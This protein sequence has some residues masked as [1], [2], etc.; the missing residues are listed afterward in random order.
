MEKR[1]TNTNVTKNKNMNKITMNNKIIACNKT[2]MSKNMMKKGGGWKRVEK[3]LQQNKV[4]DHM[5]DYV[6]I[7][8]YTCMWHM[9]LHDY[10]V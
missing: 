8:V 1:I 10:V 6:N 9:W 3:S 7:H 2:M 4:Q 5:Y